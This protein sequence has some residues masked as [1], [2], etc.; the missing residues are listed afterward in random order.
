VTNVCKII[1]GWATISITFI[2]YCD[3]IDKLLKH[4][5]DRKY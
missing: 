1:I 3:T 2:A 5:R 4:Q